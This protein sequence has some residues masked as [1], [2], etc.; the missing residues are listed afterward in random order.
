MDAG[1]SDLKELERAHRQH[2]D[3]RTEA[4]KERMDRLHEALG[5]LAQAA[6][7][8]WREIDP[9]IGRLDSPAVIDGV[10]LVDPL[11]TN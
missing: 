1:E 2:V 7:E 3:A 6:N 10:L 9:P 8:R 4:A 11:S 5:D